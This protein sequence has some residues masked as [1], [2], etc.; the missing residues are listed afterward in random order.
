[1]R[2]GWSPPA[3]PVHALPN[4]ALNGPRPAPALDLGGGRARVVIGRAVDGRACPRL[5]IGRG[6]SLVGGQFAQN[7]R[8]MSRTLGRPAGAAVRH[9]LQ[10]LL[11]DVATHSRKFKD[12]TCF[13]RCDTLNNPRSEADPAGC[14]KGVI[15]F[16]CALV[17]RG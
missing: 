9:P 3:A 6:T 16:L 13:P 7:E 11:L 2:G 17:R 15:R 4:G 5:T 12:E 10:R 1:M 14:G 8:N